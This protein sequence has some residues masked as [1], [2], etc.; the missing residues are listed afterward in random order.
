MERGGGGVKWPIVSKN[1]TEYFPLSSKGFRLIG[2]IFDI[3]LLSLLEEKH[4]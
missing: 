4:S 1:K 2:Y 3:F